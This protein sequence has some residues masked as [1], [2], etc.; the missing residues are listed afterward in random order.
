MKFIKGMM[1]G[2]IFAAGV[3]MMYNDSMG[4]TKKKMI[5]SGKKFLKDMGM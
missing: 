4:K 1:V 3:M 2:T 5:K